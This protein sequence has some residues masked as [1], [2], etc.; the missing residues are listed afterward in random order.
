[1]VMPKFFL[2]CRSWAKTNLGLHELPGSGTDHVDI[3]PQKIKT[4]RSTWEDAGLYFGVIY[5]SVCGVSVRDGDMPDKKELL[6]MI[7][8]DY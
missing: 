4:T 7:Y 8:V 2:E 5:V 6:S 3:T 1:M